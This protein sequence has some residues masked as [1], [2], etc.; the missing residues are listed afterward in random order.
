MEMNS[1]SQNTDRAAYLWLPPHNT[2][3]PCRALA[4][5]VYVI[6]SGPECRIRL[7]DESIPPRHS[8]LLLSESVASIETLA[9][10]FTLLV[11]GTSTSKCHLKDGDILEFGAIRMVFRRNATRPGSLM[12]ATYNDTDPATGDPASSPTENSVGQMT[13]LEL[14][15]AMNEAMTVLEEM[16]RPTA[17]HVTTML[18]TAESFGTDGAHRKGGEPKQVPPANFNRVDLHTEIAA[19][20]ERLATFERI[21][22]QVVQQQQLMAHTMQSMSEQLAKLR[23]PLAPN[24]SPQRRASA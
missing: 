24:V 1:T 13:A 20:R 6:G 7:G 9:K 23:P 14:V 21:I 3:T 22:E 15:E 4:S 5:G 10:G 8:T 18:Q 12:P 2:R 19:Q 17:D 11:N 16:D